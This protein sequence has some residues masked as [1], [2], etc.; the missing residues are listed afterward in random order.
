[1]SFC[2]GPALHPDTYICIILGA[3]ATLTTLSSAAWKKGRKSIRRLLGKDWAVSI[4]YFY[5]IRE[6]WLKYLDFI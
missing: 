6:K 4:A 5:E 1:M 2:G 3:I